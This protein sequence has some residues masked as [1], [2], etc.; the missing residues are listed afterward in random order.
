MYYLFFLLIASSLWNI[1]EHIVLDTAEVIKMRGP[2]A[3]GSKTP[4]VGSFGKMSLIQHQRGREEERRDWDCQQQII[5]QMRQQ[6]LQ[7]F[8]AKAA[9]ECIVVEL[10]G[11]PRGTGMSAPQG[12]FKETSRVWTSCS[13]STSARKNLGHDFSRRKNEMLSHRIKNSNN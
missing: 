10:Q 2:H 8:K 6:A 1:I 12:G 4:N 9:E 11:S 3:V 7:P 5:L 13:S